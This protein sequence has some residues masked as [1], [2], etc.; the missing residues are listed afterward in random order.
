MIMNTWYIEEVGGYVVGTYQLTG[1]LY[2]DG[3][4][5]GSK[6]YAETDDCIISI[7]KDM[8]AKIISECGEAALYIFPLDAWEVRIYV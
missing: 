2:Y 7:A 1:V 4:K 6:I 8:K 5:Q 3:R